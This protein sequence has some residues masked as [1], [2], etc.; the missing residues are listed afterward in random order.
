MAGQ[1]GEL[2]SSSWKAQ[3]SEKQSFDWGRIELLKPDSL[4]DKVDEVFEESQSC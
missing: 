1:A 4:A 3:G 2:L